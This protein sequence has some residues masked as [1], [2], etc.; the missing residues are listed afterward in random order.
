VKCGERWGNDGLK[1]VSVFACSEEQ[2]ET[3]KEKAAHVGAA[4]FSFLV[5]SAQQLT[6]SAF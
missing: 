5:T 6:N 4:E 1:G 2:K 3:A